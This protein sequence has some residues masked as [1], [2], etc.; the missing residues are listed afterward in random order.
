MG[1]GFGAPRLEPSFHLQ[2]RAQGQ[3]ARSKGKRARLNALH[4]KPWLAPS[5]SL[6]GL[7]GRV[8]G[9]IDHCQTMGIPLGE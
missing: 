8:D 1:V 6:V 2:A 5:L 7:L 9:D 3:P 4:G